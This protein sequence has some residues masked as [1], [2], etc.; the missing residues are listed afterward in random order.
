MSLLSRLVQIAGASLSRSPRAGASA[1]QT[2]NPLPLSPLTDPTTGV[3]LPQRVQPG[4]YPG[5]STLAQQSYWDAATRALILER[6]TKPP[7]NRFFNQQEE[8]TMRAVVA[9]I[10]PQDD[11]VE[12]RRIDLLS[13]IDERLYENR[14]EGYRYADMP[15]DQEAYRIAA[16]AFERMAQELYGQPFHA[17]ETLAQEKILR[18]VHDAKPL[19][20]HDI[21]SQL[22]IERFWVLLVGDCCAV[23][24]AHPYAW[25]EIGFGGPAYPR[26]Y[27]RLEEGEPEPWEVEEVRYP[28]GPPADTLSGAEEAHGTNREHQ[29]HPGQAGTH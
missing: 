19:A 16:A 22:N 9:R 8:Q 28:W 1:D 15:S 6:M 11:R 18:S 5:F 17:L 26:G 2:K 21:W 12:S 20:A 24:Y 7:R 14:I 25:D 4:Y 27:M 3:P 10:L 23:Y 29:S 13:G